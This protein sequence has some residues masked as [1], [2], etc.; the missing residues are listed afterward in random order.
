MAGVS[1]V[2][3]KAE[4]LAHEERTR[5]FPVGEHR[6]FMQILILKELR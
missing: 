4:K 2:A 5:D 6:Y 3:A 1:L